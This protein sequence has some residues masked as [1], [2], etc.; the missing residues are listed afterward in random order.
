MSEQST[1]ERSGDG[2]W[3]NSGS[4][5]PNQGWCV[6]VWDSP[7]AQF[8]LE[9]GGNHC[10]PGWAC[11]APLPTSNQIDQIEGYP[12]FRAFV[13]CDASGASS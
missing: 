10:E 8:R 1:G 12:G 11:A 2:T 13:C 9:P 5:P 6:F 7:T 4:C 3:G